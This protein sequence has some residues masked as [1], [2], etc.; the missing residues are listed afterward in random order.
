MRKEE[1]TMEEEQSDDIGGK[2]KGANNN[3][4][5]GIRDI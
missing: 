3:D 2:A 4:Q 1:G 5:F